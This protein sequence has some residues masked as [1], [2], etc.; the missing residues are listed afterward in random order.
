MLVAAPFA[1]IGQ[2][3]PARAAALDPDASVPAPPYNSAFEQHRSAAPGADE[4]TPDNA[5]RSA[6]AQVAGAEAAAMDHSKM[7]HSK[8]N[9]GPVDQ[10]KPDHSKMD[11]GKPDHSKMDHGKMDHSKMDHSKHNKHEGKE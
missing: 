6:N 9:H 8:M 10:G 2:Q 5:W 3:A 7:D 1:A 11:H 4:V